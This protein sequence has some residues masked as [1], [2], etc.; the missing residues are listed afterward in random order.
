[1]AIR[2]GAHRASQVSL[3]FLVTDTG[4]GIPANKQTTIFDA[5]TQADGS[6]TRRFG[7]TGLGLTLS[8]T[9]VTVMGGRLCV[10]SEPGTGSTFH[11]A[12]EFATPAESVVSGCLNRSEPA[13]CRYS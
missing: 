6:T 5:F 10:V 11:F 8:A 7:G 1:V 13:Q 4:I 3:E 2:E 9:L 12:V